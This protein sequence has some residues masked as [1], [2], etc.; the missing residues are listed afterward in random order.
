MAAKC[1]NGATIA[2]SLDFEKK[3]DRKKPAEVPKRGC[4]TCLP[5]IQIIFSEY[6][7]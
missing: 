1:T 3:T 4:H 2:A 7:V 6:V 5:Q